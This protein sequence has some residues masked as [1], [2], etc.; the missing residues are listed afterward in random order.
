MRRSRGCPIASTTV[1]RA[2]DLRAQL[3]PQEAKI[4]LRLRALRGHGLH[5]RRQVPI[6]T[7]I[8]DFAC[9]KA[10]LVVEIDGGQHGLIPERDESRDADLRRLGFRVLRF[11]NAEVDV[12]PDAVAE[13]IYRRMT[14]DRVYPTLPSP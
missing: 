6:G 3:T 9:L 5:F 12:D 14:D 13:T 2:R 4:W 10:R 11:W 8:V 7:Y 1:R